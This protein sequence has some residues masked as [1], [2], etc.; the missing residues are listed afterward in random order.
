VCHKD[1]KEVTADLKTIC[2]ANNQ[3]IAQLELQSFATKWD[4]KY[5][6]I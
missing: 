1:L 6:V 5:P 4:E 3:E 2:T